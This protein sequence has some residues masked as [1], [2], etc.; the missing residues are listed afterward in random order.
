MRLRQ[1][2][3]ALD[4]LRGIAVLMVI[5]HNVQMFEPAPPGQLNQFY[6]YLFNF[7]WMGV[8][9][10]FV[11]S[12]FLITGI[13]LDTRDEP[14]R[15]RNFA[16][17]RV[18]RIF[19]LYYGTLLLLF[20]IL[21]WLGWQPSIYQQEAP[22]QIWH[23]LYLSN[24]AE[25][26]GLSGDIYL[27]HFWSLAVEEQFYLLWPLVLLW[28]RTPRQVL[29]ASLVL[30]ALSGLSRVLAW[31]M[32]LDPHAVYVM[33]PCRMNALTLGAAA[34][35]AIRDP[36]WQVWLRRHHA[37][38]M[39]FVVAWTAGIFLLTHGF[40][41]NS[42]LGQT[43]GFGTLAVLFAA[44]VLS[45]ALNDTA[46][47]PRTSLWH[48]RP[49]ASAGQ[50]SYGMYVIHKPLHDLFSRPVLAWFGIHTSGSAPWAALHVA[51]SMVAA[52]GAAMLSYHLFEVRFLRL[53]RYFV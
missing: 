34:A 30:A 27:P 41:R 44:L 46:D 51:G 52:Y 21:P 19:P 7:G 38:W 28:C 43:L 4:G 2:L 26:L 11:L 10:F 22:H 3:P 47:R 32:G 42:F 23:W 53:K 12:G 8:Q 50:Y 48:L 49:L 45:A 13:L 25:A 6:M 35:C 40:P 9:L 39:F 36:V 15:W 33:T 16:A 24:W 20:V 29:A 31:H 1:H 18:L 17:R 5:A 37:Q 14:H